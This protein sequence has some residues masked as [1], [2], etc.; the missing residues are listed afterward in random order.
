MAGA[1][2]VLIALTCLLQQPAREQ[3]AASPLPQGTARISGIVVSGEGTGRAIRG[4]IVTVTGGEIPLGRSVTTSEDGAFFFAS[5]PAGS[6]LI[7]VSKPAY[8]PGA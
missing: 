8:L 6:Y 3:T 2:F 4:A 7:N 1:W 5:L